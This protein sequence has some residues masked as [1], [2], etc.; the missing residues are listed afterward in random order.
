MAI[1]AAARRLADGLLTGMQGSPNTPDEATMI[2][3]GVNFDGGAPETWAMVTL[4]QQQHDAVIA[5]LPGRSF[6]SD[7]TIT[8]ATPPQLSSEVTDVGEVTVTCDVG[9]AG[10][11]GLISWECVP[12]DG[13]ARQDSGTAVA[14]VDTW[15]IQTGQQGSYA[16][17]VD[18]EQFGSGEELFNDA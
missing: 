9:D 6:L 10:Y 8:S 14:G 7:D 5:A 2:S 13:I 4:T 11:D 12:P 3:K 1:Y 15:V 18:V 17:R 16:V